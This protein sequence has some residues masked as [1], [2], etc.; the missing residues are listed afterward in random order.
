MARSTPAQKPRGLARRM[1]M[2]FG[3]PPT[4]PE[5][6]DDQQGRADRDRAVGDVERRIVPVAPMKKQEVDYVT[7]RDSIHQVTDCAAEN[8]REPGAVP[9]VATAPQQ[10]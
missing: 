7:E 10:P 4:L 3:I 5:G 1:S 8:E 6:I 9:A 2:A